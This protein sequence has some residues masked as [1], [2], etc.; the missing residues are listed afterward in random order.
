MSERPRHRNRVDIMEKTTYGSH[1]GEGGGVQR[2]DLGVE[3][4]GRGDERLDRAD[5]LVRGLG[6][7]A[8]V[9]DVGDEGGSEYGAEEL[10]YGEEGCLGWFVEA[11]VVAELCGIGDGG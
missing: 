1:G 6:R 2:G 10:H 9:A 7:G 11:G 3:V 4:G 5:D 8:D